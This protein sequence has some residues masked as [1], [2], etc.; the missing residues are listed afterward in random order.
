MD[1]PTA[2]DR[3]SD[4]EARAVMPIL[5]ASV[6]ST[7]GIVLRAVGRNSRLVGT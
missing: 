6:S 1:V 4:R 2:Y 3:P 7:P 5:S